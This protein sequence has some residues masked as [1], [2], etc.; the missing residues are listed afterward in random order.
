MSLQQNDLLISEANGRAPNEPAAQLPAAICILRSLVM[1][2]YR[3][4][5]CDLGRLQID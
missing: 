3:H 1:H 2:L 4:L 5:H